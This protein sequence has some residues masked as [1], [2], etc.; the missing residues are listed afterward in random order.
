MSDEEPDLIQTEALA[1]VLDAP[2]AI[3]DSAHARATT[4]PHSKQHC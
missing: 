4:N 3:N 2:A 1:P